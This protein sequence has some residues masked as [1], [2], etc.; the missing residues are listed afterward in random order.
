VQCQEWGHWTPSQLWQKHAGPESK[1]WEEWEYTAE[2]TVPVCQACHRALEGLQGR[3]RAVPL[4]FKLRF[5]GVRNRRVG[6]CSCKSC[7]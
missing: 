6:A 7:A 3:T 5:D 4:P 1:A 2:A